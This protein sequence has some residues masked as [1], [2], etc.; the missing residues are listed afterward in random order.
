LFIDE[1]FVGDETKSSASGPSGA[2]PSGGKVSLSR[3]YIFSK[4]LSNATL[5]NIRICRGKSIHGYFSKRDSLVKVSMDTF[6]LCFP[7]IWW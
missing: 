5:S 7:M 2:A 3:Y 6:T 1:K 4:F